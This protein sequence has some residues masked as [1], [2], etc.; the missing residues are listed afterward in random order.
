M[1]PSVL[2]ITKICFLDAALE[3]IDEVKN[4]VDLRVIIEIDP[5]SKDKNIINIDNLPD[6]IT[7]IDVKQLLNPS[8]YL[9]F[10]PYIHGCKSFEFLVHQQNKSFSISSIK[11]SYLLYKKTKKV[12]SHF[13]HFDDVSIR[14]LTFAFFF[15]F[16][17]AKLIMN[18]H[19][20]IQ[21][22]GEKNIKYLFVRK[23]F[24]S[25][26]SKFITFSNYSKSIFTQQFGKKFFCINLNLK[27]YKYYSNFFHNDKSSPTY[28]TFIGRVSEYKGIDI[29]LDAIAILNLK[30]PKTKYLIAGAPNNYKIGEFLKN[31]YSFT[32]IKF[33][34][35]HLSNTEVC[36][37]IQQSKVI[38]CPYRDATQSGVIMTSLALFT[39]II[40]SN[41]GGL[42]E[43][44][45][46]NITGMIVNADAESFATAIETFIIDEFKD[47]QLS[48]NIL[49][50]GIHK[51]KFGKLK[52]LE[53]YS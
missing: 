44:V 42:P 6:D 48:Q 17:K 10:K 26:V 3:Y 49:N 51:F 13:I 43:Y 9:N 1:K 38:V 19:D 5:F 22:S 4:Y 24:Y 35:N 50:L 18:V 45:H 33:K 34:L 41:Q 30:Y 20:P 8:D 40:V 29:F 52:I 31:K 39:P 27:P 47:K 25:K 16:V 2:F 36:E 15:N 11:K 7:F 21:H 53:L 28:I 37:F 12:L 32:N 14:L 23:M 46:D